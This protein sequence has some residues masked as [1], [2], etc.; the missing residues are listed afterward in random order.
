MVDDGI[1]QRAVRRCTLAALVVLLTWA[2]VSGVP[3][4]ADP[5]VAD[6]PGADPV[7][8]TQ[9]DTAAGVGAAADKAPD[10]GLPAVDQAAAAAADKDAQGPAPATKQDRAIGPVVDTV[11]PV[12]N[13]DVGVTAPAGET[14]APAT[15]VTEPNT[16]TPAP[17][18]E[19]TEPNTRTPAPAT[20]V[21][22]PNTQTPAPASEPVGAAADPLPT[23]QATVP[24]PP[25]PPPA[26][27]LVPGADGGGAAPPL[28]PLEPAPVEPVGG[29]V[30][31]S[32][33]HSATAVVPPR[34]TAARRIALGPIPAGTHRAAVRDGA[35]ILAPGAATSLPSATDTFHAAPKP[36]TAPAP[37]RKARTRQAPPALFVPPPVG[38][39]GSGTSAASGAVSSTA[40]LAILSFF[41]LVPC[42][43]YGRVVVAP[44]RSRPMLFVSLLERPG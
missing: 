26:A 24:E 10:A 27:P 13:P 33:P 1:H 31:P 43:V 38:T 35:L 36:P 20:E 42:L 4:Y 2:V 44:A 40:A 11:P 39:V 7:A 19:V 32:T 15:E 23:M 29:S 12:T 21:T 9:A 37:P 16:Q 22:E 6:P 5:G 30:T 34:I 14:P 3:A 8:V 41:L 25:P 18:T 17:A 28:P